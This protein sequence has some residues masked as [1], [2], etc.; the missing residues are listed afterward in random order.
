M[1]LRSGKRVSSMAR[2]KIVFVIV[3][4]P[5]D[6]EALGILLERIFDKNRVFIF[7]VHGDI[8]TED[9]STAVNILSKIGRLVESYAKSNHFTKTHFQEVIHLI[10]MDGA[11]IPAERVVE[12]SSAESVCYTNSEIRT[13]DVVGIQRRN[14][15][16]RGCIDKLLSTK[17]IWGNVPYQAYYMSCNLDHVLYGLQ[18]ASEKE[19]EDNSLEFARKY[20]DDIDGFVRFMCNSDFS[21]MDG[22]LESWKYIKEGSR[23]LERHS[24]FG[25]C[26]QLAEK[27]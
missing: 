6:D 11:Y 5:S 20:R 25:I 16:K 23:S 26:L 14:A 22:Y 10:D 1:H 24:N 18:N 27:N 7:I 8:T 2:K 13:K 3:E 12:D 21:V 4:G 17:T 15:Q 19:K 9:D